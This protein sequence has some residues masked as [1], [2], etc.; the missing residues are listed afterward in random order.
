MRIKVLLFGQLKDIVGRQEEN[1]DL[2]PG[3]S[4]S[5]VVARYAEQ[6]PKFKPMAGSI[7]CSV[8]REYA[9]ASIVLH[10][11]DE[12]G[13]LPPVSGGGPTT[14]EVHS[15]LHSE[16]C[17]IVREK[18]DSQKIADALK[19]PEDGATAIFEGI[20]RNNT[21]GRST[22]YL[23]YEAYDAMAINEMEKLSHVALEQFKIRDVRLVHRLGR[24][25]IGETSVLVVV[26][27]AHRGA[28]FEA[29]RWLIDTLKKTVPIW[30]KEHFEDGAVWVDGE[31][32]PE[33]IRARTN[34]EP[35]STS[36]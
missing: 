17:A 32:F 25:E 10:D 24:L 19:A 2:Q 6:F 22:L 27:S 20:V 12:V 9:A 34:D 3:A 15:E 7:A 31:P 1:L 14:A 36:N 18:I 23:N 5:D 33:E 21:R 28:A 29:C 30:K 11:G 26:A 13:L 4:L 35:R 16:H 8:N